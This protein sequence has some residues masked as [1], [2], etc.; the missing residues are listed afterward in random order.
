MEVG[1]QEEIKEQA[2][3]PLLQQT[4]QAVLEN[5]IAIVSANYTLLTTPG[6]QG[7]IT[8]L[9]DGTAVI[10]FI[11]ER[12]TQLNIPSNK[13]VLSRHLCRGGNCPVE[14]L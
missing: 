6:S 8:A 2:F 14:W 13:M 12:L 4:M 7:V 10:D 11:V 1:L 9:E 3:D 5:N